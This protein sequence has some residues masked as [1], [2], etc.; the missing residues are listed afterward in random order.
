MD[1]LD[2]TAAP[3]KDTALTSLA[4]LAQLPSVAP[5]SGGITGWAVSLMETLGGPGA[6]VATILD[7]VFPPIPSELIL[8]LAG[9]TAYR[10]GMTLAGAIIWSTV[11]SLV[12]ALILYWAG[13]VLGRERVNSIARKVPLVDVHDIDK[14]FEWFER[15]GRTVTFFGRMVPM[16][17]SMVSIPAGVERMPL[18]IFCLLTTL[19]SL[20]WNA[21]L[22]LGGY[23][24][25]SQWARIEEWAGWFQYAVIAFFVILIARW[26]R[27]KLK[28]RRTP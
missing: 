15:H 20:C 7:S 18:A 25:G 21:A 22:I 1:D 8:P 28:G 14:G 17:R 27:Q 4:L 3:A 19:G 11:G 26:V 9:F 6:M 10:G 24:L 5:D 12:G 16:V 13:A 23:A 2:L